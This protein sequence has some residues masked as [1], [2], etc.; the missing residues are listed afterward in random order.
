M[1]SRYAARSFAIAS[2]LICMAGPLLAAPGLEPAP[3]P[4]LALAGLFVGMAGAVLGVAALVAA[5]RRRAELRVLGRRVE[6]LDARLAAL[7]ESATS[8]EQQL[9]HERQ[10]AARFHTVEGWIPA[11]EHQIYDDL[12]KLE[13]SINEAILSLGSRLI[14]LEAQQAAPSTP[15]AAAALPWPHWLEGDDPARTEIRR[16]V[17]EASA[18]AASAVSSCLERWRDV[19]ERNQREQETQSEDRAQYS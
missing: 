12:H 2:T 9:Q 4:T 15:V 5:Q 7:N 14:K 16:I 18:T 3:P 11:L 17:T 6:A 13:H 1:A 8:R 10:M 19:P